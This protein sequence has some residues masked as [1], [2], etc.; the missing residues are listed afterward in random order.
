MQSKIL[1]KK[2]TRLALINQESWRLVNCLLKVDENLIETHFKIS[3]SNP[4][5]FQLKLIEKINKHIN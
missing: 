4:K 2:H 5:A 1:I 3:S